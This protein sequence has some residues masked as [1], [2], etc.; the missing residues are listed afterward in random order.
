MARLRRDNQPGPAACQ[1][2][3]H[4][5]SCVLSTMLPVLL[6][7]PPL[8]SSPSVSPSCPPQTSPTLSGEQS[9]QGILPSP[10]LRPCLLFQP[11][12]LPLQRAV[13]EPQE[14]ASQ[15]RL[16]PGG[17][18][19]PHKAG[20]GRLGMGSPVQVRPW[21]SWPPSWVVS[22]SPHVQGPRIQSHWGSLRT[23]L[24]LQGGPQ[25]TVGTLR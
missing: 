4:C 21:P 11:A 20:S 1:G 10:P 16:E 7:T 14:R 12:T 5:P 22:G 15:T 23:A 24:R 8:R 9:G 6:E 17:R 13:G 18:P 2:H 3:G 19:R 25:A